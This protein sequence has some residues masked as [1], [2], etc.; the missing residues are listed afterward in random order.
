MD[1]KDS[2]ERMAKF[3]VSLDLELFWGLYAGHQ[4]DECA[5]VVE[6]ARR[7]VEDLLETFS[8][9]RVRA[10]WAPVGFLFCRS[11]DELLEH[12][13]A[14][15]PAYRHAGLS[16]Y[17]QLA[18]IGESEKDDPYHYAPS[19][20][21]RI[22][23]TPGQ[24][25][26]S[27]TFANFRCLEDGQ[28]A[29][30][31]EADIRAAVQVARR[32]GIIVRSLVVP[33]NQIDADY[34][35]RCR[36]LGISAYRG[37]PDPW[38]YRAQQRWRTGGLKTGL[39]RVARALDTVVPVTGTRCVA[40]GVSGRDVPIN[41]PATRRLRPFVDRHRWWSAMH[42]RRIFSE[43][44]CAARTGGLFHL[45]WH[46]RDFGRKPSAQIDGLRRLLDRFHGWR[47][48]GR[49]ESV[50]MHEVAMGRDHRPASPD[51]D[52]SPRRGAAR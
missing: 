45:W 51:V 14:H 38:P 22:A 35:R 19:L 44:D 29:V 27:R 37:R 33:G 8:A 7:A 48:L 13:P 41:V 4:L 47:K 17:A 40:D 24:E 28:K 34:L 31:F 20:I 10:T 26:A 18:R 16:P 42:R 52:R 46:V 36:R 1:G 9:Y 23:A 39:S 49:M 30:E 21:D 32:R 11:K 2:L 25:V 43:L 50:T 3:V 12:L 5:G 15:L 6:T